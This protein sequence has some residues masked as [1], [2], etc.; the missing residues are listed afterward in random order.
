MQVEKTSTSIEI[1]TETTSNRLWLFI[2][3]VVKF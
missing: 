1:N 2:G 3:G